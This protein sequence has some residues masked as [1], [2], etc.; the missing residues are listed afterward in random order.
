MTYP[1]EL[2]WVDPGRMSGTPCFR[3]SRVPVQYIFDYLEAGDSLDLFLDEFPT[4]SRERALGVLRVAGRW[5]S[6]HAHP[7]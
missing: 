1:T 7:A 6:D 5:V 4:V 2:V 3:D